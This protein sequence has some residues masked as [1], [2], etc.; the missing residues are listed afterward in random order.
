[1]S[2]EAVA[3][4]HRWYEEVWNKGR[5]SAIDELMAFKSFHAAYRNA[6]PDLNVVVD[7]TIAEDDRVVLRWT[8]TATHAGDG[9]EFPASGKKVQ[10]TGISIARVEN[11]KLVEGWNSFDQLGLLQ[12]LGVV[13]GPLKCRR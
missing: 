3:L 5:V 8:A 4:G 2:Q 1:M 6:F 9:L 11:G 12:Q 10:F 7:D 13:A